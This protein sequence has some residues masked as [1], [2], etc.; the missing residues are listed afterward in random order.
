M[1]GIADLFFSCFVSSTQTSVYCSRS[2]NQTH[3]EVAIK[4]INQKFDDWNDVKSF[5]EFQAIRHLSQGCRHLCY[6]YDI[7][8]E[9]DCSLH[10]AFELMPDGTLNDYI[11][12]FKSRGERV[13][14]SLIGPILWQVL[15]GL[16]YIHSKGYMHRDIKPENLLMRGS[17]CKVADFSLARGVVATSCGKKMTSYVS[18]RWYRAPEIILCAPRYSTAI[19]MFALGCVMAEL[20]RLEPLFPGTGEI[21]QLHMILNLWGPMHL[22]NWAEG[23]RLAKRLGIEVP[24]RTENDDWSDKNKIRSRV[25]TADLISISLLEE[26]LKLNPDERMTATAALDH[27]FFSNSKTLRMHGQK[28]MAT[29]IM[30]IIKTPPKTTRDFHGDFHLPP[31]VSI[32]KENGRMYALSDLQDPLFQNHQDRRNFRYDDHGDSLLN[33]ASK[34]KKRMDMEYHPS[35]AFCMG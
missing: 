33:S 16:Q 19:D 34:K 20:Y 32:E 27:G 18:T 11:H 6:I 21:V 13:S 22:A 10:F 30:P 23:V 24:H 9:Q 17:I 5:R 15:K 4:T 7:M 8:R 12:S 2:I 29:S 31:I 25:P 28:A 14:P 35:R 26:L 3:Q 1:N